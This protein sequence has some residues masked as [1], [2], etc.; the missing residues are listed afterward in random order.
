MAKRKVQ[1][2][3]ESRPDVSDFN[4]F[5]DETT[6]ASGAIQRIIEK[7][8]SYSH[9]EFDTPEYI[10]EDIINKR[11]TDGEDIFGRA[12]Y[13]AVKYIELDETFP[14]HVVDNQDKFKHLIR[15]N[16]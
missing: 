7:V 14:S 10:S 1:N 13:P 12:G 6:N 3:T 5:S 4:P 16:V 2:R 11:L 8:Q 15:N 9:Q